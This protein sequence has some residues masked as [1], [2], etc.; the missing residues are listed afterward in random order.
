M[1]LHSMI[2]LTEEHPTMKPARII[3]LLAALFLA[4]SARADLGVQ[5]PEGSSSYVWNISGGYAFIFWDWPGTGDIFTAHATRYAD[6]LEA[7]LAGLHPGLAYWL[8][9]IGTTANGDLLFAAYA[10]VHGTWYYVEDFLL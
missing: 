9:Y 2:N 8:D 1:M 3:L 7:S 5:Y 10:N 6:P 4:S